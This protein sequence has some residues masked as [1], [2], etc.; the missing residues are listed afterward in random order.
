[1]GID[2]F[3]TSDIYGADYSEVILEK[4]LEGK[5]N[6]VVIATKFGFTYD[7]SKREITGTGFS[8]EYIKCA[9]E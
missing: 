3:D 5:R 8:K 6:E 7:S 9:C 4:A 2:F 1:M